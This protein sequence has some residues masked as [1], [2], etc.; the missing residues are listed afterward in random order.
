MCAIPFS[1][2]N[3]KLIPSQFNRQTEVCDFCLNKAN[4]TLFQLN[5]FIKRLKKKKIR[6][7]T[8]LANAIKYSCMCFW[9]EARP[10]D[11]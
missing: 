8:V 3:H 9:K 5:A 10:Y 1:N 6:F 11:F 7:R 4:C 2:K